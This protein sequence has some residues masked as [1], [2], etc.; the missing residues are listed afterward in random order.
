MRAE[1][2]Q[3][4]YI[5]RY[6]EKKFSEE[7]S[8][9]F[10]LQMK[11][12]PSFRLD[13][14]QQK[15]IVHHFKIC[16]FEN[17]INDYRKTQRKKRLYKW[18]W[19]GFL[20]CSVSASIVVYSISGEDTKYTT[21]VTTLQNNDNIESPTSNHLP[22]INTTD[23]LEETNLS[24]TNSEQLSPEMIADTLLERSAST[25]KMSA[26]PLNSEIS[27]EPDSL[28]SSLT[29]ANK[30]MYLLWR[31]DDSFMAYRRMQSI[32]F[33]IKEAA[34]LVRL[35][36]TIQGNQNSHL[37]FY[38]IAPSGKK[39]TIIQKQTFK[40]FNLKDELELKAEKGRWAV[41][42]QTHGTGMLYV[43]I[44]SD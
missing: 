21:E 32:P 14:E 41:Q 39:Y 20:I 44:Q 33:Y 24:F 31:L 12:D 11:N 28:T 27:N 1:L 7:E 30:K 4:E 22:I 23:T 8:L 26:F 2:E 42:I 19:G 25:E 6:L 35:S 36:Y 16:V 18:L 38:L 15:A 29:D 43:E 3:I 13:V 40:A 17:K 5:E 37:Q 10:E 34:S 9:V